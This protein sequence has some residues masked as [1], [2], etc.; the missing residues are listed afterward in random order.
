LKD[1]QEAH[2]KGRNLMTLKFARMQ[3]LIPPLDQAN[4]PVIDEIVTAESAWMRDVSARFPHVVKY[5][6]TG[7][8]C[9]GDE[10]TNTFE[11][12][13]RCELETYS[14]RTLTLYED[15]LIRAMDNNINLIEKRYI[16]L[17]QSLGY[18]SLQQV[19][20]MLSRRPTGCP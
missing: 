18:A 7:G 1:L 5:G 8:C 17:I 12:Y 11:T 15:D 10:N 16:R 20:Q 4:L 2:K 9:A 19:E 3:N 14:Y 6:Q 13:T